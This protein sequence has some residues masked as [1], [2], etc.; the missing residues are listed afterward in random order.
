[1]DTSSQLQGGRVCICAAK[2]IYEKPLCSI[3]ENL[4]YWKH[5]AFILSSLFIYKRVVSGSLK[6]LCNTDIICEDLAQDSSAPCVEGKHRAPL[7]HM[8]PFTYHHQHCI[9]EN[10]IASVQLSIF[11]KSKNKYIKKIFNSKDFKT[12]FWKGHANWIVPLVMSLLELEVHNFLHF[13]NPETF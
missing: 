4:N 9:S 11:S 8:L 12:Y 2:C 10:T 1:M 7:M 13:H 6:A 5:V 3:T